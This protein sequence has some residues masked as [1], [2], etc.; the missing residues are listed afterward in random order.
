MFSIIR[1]NKERGCTR[2]G[3]SMV[4]YIMKQFIELNNETFE[5]KELKYEPGYL[6]YKTLDDCYSKFSEAKRSVY[7]NWVEWR[8][9][10]DSDNSTDYVF[11]RMTILSYNV[12]MFTL[13]AEVYNKIGELIGYLYITKTRQ[14]FWI[15]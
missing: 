14:E 5:M 8:D 2:F 13:A 4:I 7:Y 3:A 1:L 15:A 9:E 12:Y 11:G 10:L 6:E